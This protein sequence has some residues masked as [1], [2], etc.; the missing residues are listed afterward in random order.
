MSRKIKIAIIADSMCLPRGEKEG[1]VPFEA[2]Y[3][4]VLEDTFNNYVNK[5]KKPRF[6]VKG[7]RSR[8]LLEVKDEWKEV[9]DFIKPEIVIVNVGITDCAPR[10]LNEKKRKIVDGIKIDFVKNSIINYLKKNRTKL[11][12]KDPTKRFVTIEVFEKEYKN[13]INYLTPKTQKIIFIGILNVS[14]DLERKSPG[15]LESVKLYNSVLSS[16]ADNKKIYFLDVNKEFEQNNFNEC[17]LDDGYHFSVKG[18]SIVAGALF[19]IL[20]QDFE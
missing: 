14:E 4:I 15:Y 16:G 7:K 12:L 8:T 5:E 6:I 18:N 1:D 13:I 10:I 19:D 9:I 11:I 20:R 17:R 2:T 3:P